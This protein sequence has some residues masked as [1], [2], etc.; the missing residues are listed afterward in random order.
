MHS[1]SQNSLPMI[2]T[3]FLSSYTL[4]WLKQPATNFSETY[5]ETLA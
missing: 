5:P 4:N 2:N 1:E 3:D